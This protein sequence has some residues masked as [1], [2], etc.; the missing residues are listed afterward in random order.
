MRVEALPLVGIAFI[1]IGIFILIA[2]ILLSA[3]SKVEGGFVVF[4]GPIPIVG[5]TS[6]SI[7]LVLL[8]LSLILITILFLFKSF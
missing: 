8:I 4:I 3:K 2:S 6:K 7:A 5:A 1:F